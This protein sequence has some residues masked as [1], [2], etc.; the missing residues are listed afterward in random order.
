MRTGIIIHRKDAEDAKKTKTKITTTLA[1]CNLPPTSKTVFKA[2]H[3]HGCKPL[4]ARKA[5]PQKHFEKA[6]VAFQ[7]RLLSM[8]MASCAH[9]VM[10]PSSNLPARFHHVW[11]LPDPRKHAAELTDIGDLQ[12]QAHA[13]NA[14]AWIGRRLHTGEIDFL[15]CEH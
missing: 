11:Q 14:I 2:T 12:R 13:G 3:D 8:F 5:R 1:G 15:V 7:A 10:P 6:I 9:R 4:L